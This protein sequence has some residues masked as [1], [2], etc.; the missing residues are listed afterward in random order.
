MSTSIING[1]YYSRCGQMYD[2]YVVYIVMLDT[3]NYI[4]KRQLALKGCWFLTSDHTFLLTRIYEI[5]TCFIH[6]M[7]SPLMLL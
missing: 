7:H 4:H 6:T 5:I 2:F 1:I 3:I